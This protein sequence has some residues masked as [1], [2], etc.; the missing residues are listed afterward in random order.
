MR[1][2]TGMQYTIRNIPEK[3]DAALRSIARQQGK[4]LNDV[5]IQ[6]LSRGVG[7][8]EQQNRRRDLSDIAGAWREDPAFDNAVAAQDAIDAHQIADILRRVEAM[9]TL[10]DR[11]P[12]EILGYDEHGVPRS[13]R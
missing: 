10:D 3:L 1:D 13:S 8:G 9:P 7:L 12:D 5:V 6:A 4:S 2:N 11:S